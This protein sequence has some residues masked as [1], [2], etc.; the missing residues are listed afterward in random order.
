MRTRALMMVAL[1]TVAT[2]TLFA[3]SDVD[4]E[5]EITGIDAGVD[6]TRHNE[7]C[8]HTDQIYCNQADGGNGF[9]CK[10][11]DSIHVDFMKDGDDCSGT[12]NRHV[13]FRFTRHDTGEQICEVEL[14]RRDDGQG[15]DFEVVS[16]ESGFKCGGRT[17]NNQPQ[18]RIETE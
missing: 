10:D 12:A 11:G 14:H 2:T 7:R 16:Q 9:P 18:I 3:W 17:E 15:Y 5:L 4:V 13:N 1:L 6:W 8:V